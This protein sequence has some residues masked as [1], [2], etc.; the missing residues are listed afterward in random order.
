MDGEGAHPTGET[1]N[2]SSARGQGRLEVMGGQ[3]ASPPKP[4]AQVIL[5]HIQAHATWWR[6]ILQTP[7]LRS[8]PSR[9][10]KWRKPESHHSPGLKERGGPRSGGAQNRRQVGTLM[11]WISKVSR[12]FLD[13]GQWLV[14]SLNCG[15]GGCTVSKNSEGIT[16]FLQVFRLCLV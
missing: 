5:R 4:R 7:G 10:S 12:G 9:S 15:E 13:G 16:F 11:R 8:A 1:P 6:D 14:W 2:H 3:G